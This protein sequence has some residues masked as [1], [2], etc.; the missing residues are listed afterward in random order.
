MATI[1]IELTKGQAAIIDERDLSI[2]LGFFSTEDAAARAYD[3]AAVKMF[4]EFARLNFPAPQPMA[5]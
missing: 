2:D 3:A 1:E 4:G 5:G